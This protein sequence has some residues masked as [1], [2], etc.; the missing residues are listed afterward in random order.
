MTEKELKE[1]LQKKASG[2]DVEEKKIIVDERGRPQKVEVYQRHVP[3]DVK[4]IKTILARIKNG[5]W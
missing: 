2:Y 5:E 3:P 1:L 4:A